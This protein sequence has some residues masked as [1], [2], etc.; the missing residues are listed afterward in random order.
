MRSVTKGRFT[1]ARKVSEIKQHYWQKMV[2]QCSIPPQA[3]VLSIPREKEVTYRNNLICQNTHLPCFV[4]CWYPSVARQS[5]A[6]IGQLLVVW[7]QERIFTIC[8]CVKPEY[9]INKLFRPNL[10][11]NYG[12]RCRSNAF[13]SKRVKKKKKTDIWLND[14]QLRYSMSME[15]IKF[16]WC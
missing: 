4:M 6:M 9:I 12:D 8:L 10:P 3:Q 15:E 14:S 13:Q 5:E 11:W 1:L 2:S 16:S 7:L